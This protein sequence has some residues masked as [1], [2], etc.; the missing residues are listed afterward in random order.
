M[1]ILVGI[2]EAGYGPLLGPLVVSGAAFSIDRNLLEADHWQILQKSVGNTKKRLLGRLL[3]ADS[4]KA[5]NRKTG[6]RHLQRTALAA[7]KCVGHEPTNLF[8]LLGILCPDCQNRIN[9]YPW[10]KDTANFYFLANQSDIS[11]ASSVFENDMADNSIKLE[12]LKSFCLDVA[13][14][15]QMVENVKNKANVLFTATSSLIK[16]AWD[17][18]SE[19]D[20][21][22]I[23]D[24][25]GGRVHYR[26]NLQQMFDGMELTILKETPASSSYELRDGSRKMRVHFVIKADGR[27]L[28]VSLASMVSKYVRELLVENINRYFAGFDNGLKPTAGY[29]TDGL[30]F[31]NDLKQNIPHVKYDSNQ[32]IRT[33]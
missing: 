13:Y 18:F 12:S 19:D 8:E 24:R 1:A 4:K 7:L 9:D 33:R 3:I 14:Y 26:K 23:V 17:R 6:I 10:Y 20:L 30:R 31:I 2:D 29:W 27:F 16:D 22:I 21:Q 5:F 28:A 25:Q 15:N 11:I 32:L